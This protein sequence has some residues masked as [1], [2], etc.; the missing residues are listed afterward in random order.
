MSD[1]SSQ[2]SSIPPQNS[3][4]NSY[5]SLYG[6]GMPMTYS[7][8]ITV[9]NIA[10]EIEFMKNENKL[11]KQLVES[12]EENAKLQKEMNE[13]KNK[14]RLLEHHFTDSLKTTNKWSNVE[15]HDF[16]DMIY[17]ADRI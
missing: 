3:N 8:V 12:K 15:C 6:Y 14:I 13:L 2:P 4:Y 1:P 5:S 10:G 9:P 7:A 17:K 16:I 11:L